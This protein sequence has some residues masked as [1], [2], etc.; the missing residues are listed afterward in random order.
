[1]TEFTHSQRPKGRG[2]SAGR[3]RRS[4]EAFPE[5]ARTNQASERAS[6]KADMPI[7]PWMPPAMLVLPASCALGAQ[8][9][10]LFP[11]PRKRVRAQ[12]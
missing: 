6:A 9:P 1:M 8:R 5:A 11:F 12:G 2:R 4:R 10:A 3:K 7:C